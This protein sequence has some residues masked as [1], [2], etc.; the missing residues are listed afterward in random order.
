MQRRII[1]FTADEAKLT[2]ENIR[3]IEAQFLSAS[4]TLLKTEWRR[5]KSGE[6]T[7]KRYVVQS[8]KRAPRRQ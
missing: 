4:Q 6:R 2:T 3:A 7:F 8:A 5:V 1:A